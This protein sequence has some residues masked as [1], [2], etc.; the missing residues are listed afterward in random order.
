MLDSEAAIQEGL[1]RIAGTFGKVH[2]VVPVVL[3]NNHPDESTVDESTVTFTINFEST[4]DAMTAAR[5]LSGF[6]YGFSALVVRLRRQNEC[7]GHG[8]GEAGSPN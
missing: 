4:L 8:Q 2:S 1:S 5:E 6:L 3:P 7:G